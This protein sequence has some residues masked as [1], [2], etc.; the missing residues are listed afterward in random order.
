LALCLHPASKLDKAEI[1]D[2]SAVGCF[3]ANGY[4]LFNMSGNVW[5]WTR[6]LWGMDFDKLEL[7]TPMIRK[8]VS[9][10]IS[11]QDTISCESCAVVPGTTPVTTHVVPSVTGINPKIGTTIWVF[12]WCCVL[13]MFFRP[14]FWSHFLGETTYL[15]T[16]TNCV[17]AMQV[18]PLIRVSLPRCFISSP[19]N[20]PPM[21]H[22]YEYA[23]A[24]RYWLN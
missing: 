21:S 4:G 24:S 18:D 2:T 6:S 10:K 3:A 8:I 22:Y 17:P 13:P 12:G 23:S 11:P 5:E 15:C 9:G 16:H 1:N 7:P 19:E 20:Q 14:F